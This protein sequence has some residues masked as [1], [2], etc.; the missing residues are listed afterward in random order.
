MPVTKTEIDVAQEVINLLVGDKAEA[1]A[2]AEN[3]DGWLDSHGYGDVSPEAVATCGVGGGAGGG[4]SAGAGAGGASAYAAPPPAGASAV[5]QLDYIVYNNY[6]EDNSITNNIEN[7]G[8]LDFTQQV[9]DGNVAIDTDGGGFGGQVQTGDGIQVGGDV[10][11]SNL[12]TG[13]GD[14]LVD[15]STNVNAAVALGGGDATSGQSGIGDVTQTTE[16]PAD[17]GGEDPLPEA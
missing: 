16:A 2:Y 8:E 15:E 11:D 12:E 5:A 13:E 17:G 3:P 7:H 6:H 4:A 10:D 14:Q 9:G 1:E